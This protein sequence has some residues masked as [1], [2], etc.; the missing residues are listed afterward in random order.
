MQNIY[1]LRLW[2]SD[3]WPNEEYYYLNFEEALEHFKVYQH[4]SNDTYFAIEL[5]EQGKYSITTKALILLGIS[6]AEK[7]IILDVGCD[8]QFDTCLHLRQILPFIS[9]DIIKDIAITARTK[10]EKLSPSKFPMFFEILRKE[11]T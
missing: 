3:E 8:N 5:I 6:A 1:V 11:M 9:D 7:K 10:I 2:R 4:D